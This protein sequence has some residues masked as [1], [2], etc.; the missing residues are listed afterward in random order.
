[1]TDGGYV[2]GGWLATAGVLSV[3]AWAIRL[4]IKRAERDVPPEEEPPWR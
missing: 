3:Y 4:R 2:V 1:V